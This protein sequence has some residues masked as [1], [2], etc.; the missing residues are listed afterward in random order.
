MEK[1]SARLDAG[2]PQKAAAAGCMRGFEGA[3]GAV[4][5]NASA[6]FACGK[7]LP[8]LLPAA[9]AVFS[10]FAGASLLALRSTGA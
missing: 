6:A 4:G 3:F 5:S 9:S 1:A 7:A 2:K 10:V 8:G